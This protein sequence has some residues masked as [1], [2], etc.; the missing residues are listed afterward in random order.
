MAK[1]ATTHKRYWMTGFG[2][3]RM[4]IFLVLLL[5]VVSCNRG[6]G[7]GPEPL[8]CYVGG[9]MRPVMEELAQRYEKETGQPVQLD[10]GDSGELMIKIEQTR[11]GDLYVAHD[12]FLAALMRTR[13]RVALRQS[14]EGLGDQG[15][16]VARLEPVIV[17]QK[18]NPKTVRG[19]R[20]LTRPGLKLILTDAEYS[21]AGHIVGRM[22][23]RWGIEEG[24]GSNVVTRVR[25]GGEAANAV[26]IGTADASVVWNAVAHLRRDKLDVVPIEEEVALK[27][28]VDAVTT[29]TFGR[30]EMDYIRVTIATLKCSKNLK[31]A[32][33]FAEFVAAESTRSVWDSR[34]FSRPIPSRLHP[35]L[36]EQPSA[37]D[38]FVHCAAGMR[39]PVSAMAEA[40][41][42][43]RGVSLQLN[44]D[45]SNRLLG[46]IKLTRK[47]D[48]YIA[49]DTDYMDMALRDGLVA[50][51]TSMCYFVPVIMVQKGNPKGVRV[52]ADLI[53]P[54]IRVG[55]GDEKAAAVGRLMPRL[56][57][58]NGVDREV[59][60]RNVVMETP[61][62]NELGI[63]IKLG[64]I[65]AAVVWDAIAKAYTNEADAIAIE[66]GR[67]ICP[68]VGSAVLKTAKNPE[69]ARAFLDFM[70]SEKG[71]EFLKADG[72]TVDKP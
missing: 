35:A 67:N 59:W 18:G 14:K 41:E 21:T 60:K 47:G 23:R 51:S 70:V 46:Q 13:L 64:T 30:M 27:P 12:P 53:K 68:A 34:G 36:A 16:T 72:Y 48:V 54:G 69:L 57:E 24:L 22:G 50:S 7:R 43:E 52:L 65:D 29:A 66:P 62:V 2:M 20:D 45:G 1:R 49:G 58:L 19:F 40:F 10:F 63:G 28:G 9:T 42:K 8:L 38:L 37:G 6:T 15:W 56:L 3:A 11:K 25:G 32:R 5:T 39:L 31:A 44:Y 4:G 26:A 33:A 71:R 17:V 61:T 55:Q